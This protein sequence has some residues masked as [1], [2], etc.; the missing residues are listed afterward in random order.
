MSRLILL[1]F[2][3][4][5]L[6]ASSIEAQQ[7]TAP[8]DTPTPAQQPNAAPPA[9]NTIQNGIAMALTLQKKSVIFPDLATGKTHLSGWDKCKLAAN[10]SVAPSTVGAALLGSLVG[11][12]RGA[13]RG[14]GGG[15]EGYG[16]RFGADLARSASYNL[17]GPC[18][19]AS[20]TH[21]DPRFF[22]RSQL[23]FKASL[24]YAA[25]RLVY[26]RNDD[27]ERVINYSGLGGSLAAET[28]ANVYYPK[29]SRSVGDTMI[30]FSLDMVTRYAGHMLRQYLPQIDKRL[31]LSP[32]PDTR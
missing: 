32:A 26:T 7:P 23:G 17:F 18:L 12:A 2:L 10:T 21:E 13:P 28:L 6:C 14:Y 15:F 25:V 31:K 11:Q 24:K 9:Q 27:G 19:I 8:P 4:P 3:C 20:S 1:V 22:V 16:K 30:R 29:G 5:L